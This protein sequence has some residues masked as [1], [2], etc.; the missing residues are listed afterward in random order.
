VRLPFTAGRSLSTG[1]EDRTRTYRYADISIN[2]DA[3]LQYD[4]VRAV[5]FAIEQ[6]HR[7]DFDSWAGNSINSALLSNVA[8]I[9]MQRDSAYASRI[10]FTS[11][12]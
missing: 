11:K 10:A 5:A 8:G 12:S 1:I 4:D 9:N 3:H 2:D 7:H 6:I